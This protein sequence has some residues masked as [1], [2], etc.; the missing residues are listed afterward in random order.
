MTLST[1]SGGSTAASL[2]PVK[3]DAFMQRFVGDLGAAMSASL[4]VLGDKLGLYRAMDAAGHPMSPAELAARTD[5]DERYVREWLS[6]QAAAGYVE[7][8]ADAGL[9]GLSPEQA[10]ALAKEDSPAYIPGAFQIVSAMVK[11]EHKIAEAFRLFTLPLLKGA[12]NDQTDCTGF[13]ASPIN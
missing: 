6:A 11:D 4:V 12:P 9:F 1:P 13:H 3:L 2:D 8:H 5:T 10:F 7:Y